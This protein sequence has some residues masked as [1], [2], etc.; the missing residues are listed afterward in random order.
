MPRSR[1]TSPN[2]GACAQLL[3]SVTSYEQ[4]A[5][6]EGSVV[7]M[8]SV[9]EIEGVDCA[10]QARF[11]AVYPRTDSPAS[12][13]TPRVPENRLGSVGVFPGV[14]WGRVAGQ[15]GMGVARWNRGP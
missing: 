2:E 6:T 14:G 10:R 12:M 3:V 9:P 5:G 11:I 7:S 13:P 1:K 15:G 8:V 4:C